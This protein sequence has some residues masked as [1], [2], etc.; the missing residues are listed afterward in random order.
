MREWIGFWSIGLWSLILYGSVGLPE[1][2]YVGEKRLST[3]YS[4]RAVG[5]YAV[6]GMVA[7]LSVAGCKVGPDYKKPDVLVPSG[8]AS[9]R[10]TTNPTT[11]PSADAVELIRWWEN[12]GD[13][14]LTSLIDR[15]TRANLNLKIAAARVRQARAQLGIYSALGQPQVDANAGYA[16]RKGSDHIAGA[17]GPQHAS[18]LYSAGFD[19]SWELDLFGGDKRQVEVGEAQIITAVESQRDVL[20]SLQAELASSYTDLRANQK[21]LVVA[22]QTVQSQQQVANLVRSRF[23]AGLA[24]DLDVARADAQVA[25]TQAQTPLFE[26][27]IRVDMHRVGILLGHGPADNIAELETLKPIPV[28]PP[29]IPA[30]IPGDLLQRRPDIRRA[31]ADLRAVTAGIGVAKSELYP[32]F[33]LLGNIGLQSSQVKNW[34]Q[35]DSRSWSFGPQI[36]WS[37]LNAGRINSNIEVQNALQEQ[38]LLRYQQTILNSVEDVENA[39]TRY[40][41]EQQRRGLLQTSV[42]AN[43]RA[44]NLAEELYQRGLTDFTPVLDAQRSLY[45]AQDQLVS[46]E[47]NVTGFA[48]SVYKAL[49]GGWIGVEP[50]AP[51]TRP[52]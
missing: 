1:E 15:A 28:A 27:A 44:V 32:K 16:H 38:S 51:T 23:E 3:Q 21:R 7:V 22:R 43:Q 14:Q 49:G 19:A 20:V 52:K 36:N 50:P 17:N 35:A 47:G 42:N 37:I 31:E 12:L 18:D 34:W 26:A 29:Q 9:T 4:S 10:P 46:S 24:N 25:S 48:I 13:S 30:D 45:Q 41:H 40:G 11:Q 33:Y 8:Y 39:L 5:L 2:G 6:T